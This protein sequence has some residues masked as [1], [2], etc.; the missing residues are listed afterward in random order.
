MFTLKLYDRKGTELK[1][2]DIVKISDGDLFIFFCEI[3]Y[4]EKEQV[5]APF[6]TFSF[7]SFEKVTKV[8]KGATKSSE[9]RYNIWYQ[10]RDGA[11]VDDKAK[12]F[13]DYLMSWRE[14]EHLINN[15]CYRIIINPLKGAGKPAKVKI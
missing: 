10:Y 2:G 5:I 4:L 1:I 12:D 8:P 14:C 6:H 13:K 11:E 9:E 7:H 15:R 3:K